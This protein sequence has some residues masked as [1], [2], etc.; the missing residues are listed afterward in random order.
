LVLVVLVLSNRRLVMLSL[1]PFGT[2]NVW[3]GPVLVA[4]LAGGV[5][6]GLLAHM[7]KHFSLRRRARNAEKRVTLLT[8]AQDSGK[9]GE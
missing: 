7:P 5:I 1:W 9:T 4:T 3:L 6:L 2:A 8:A